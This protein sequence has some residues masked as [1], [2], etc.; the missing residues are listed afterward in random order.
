MNYVNTVKF[1]SEKDYECTYILQ[2]LAAPA[3]R[4]QRIDLY[5]KTRQVI[6]S[7]PFNTRKKD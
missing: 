6:I 4:D 5:L 1:F 2:L 7:G 3:L